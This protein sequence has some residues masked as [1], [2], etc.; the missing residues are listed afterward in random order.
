M[1]AITYKGIYLAYKFAVSTILVALF[2]FL[3]SAQNAYAHF[4]HFEPR[5]IHISEK[6]GGLQILL[7]MPLPLLL[8]DTSWRGFDSLQNVPF[9][10]QKQTEEGTQYIVDTSAIEQQFPVFSQLVTDNYTLKHANRPQ[11]SMKVTHVHIFNSDRRK[12]FSSLQ[13]AEQSFT[14]GDI[15]VDAD[16]SNLFESSIDVRLFV[17]FAVFDDSY[18]IDSDLGIHLNAIEKLA[19]IVQVHSQEGT[20]STYSSIGPLHLQFEPERGPL[21]AFTHQLGNGV[22]HILIGLD[23]VLFVLLIA[24][25]STSWLQTLKRATA[26]TIGHSIT[27]AMGLYGLIPVGTWFIPAIEILIALTILYAAIA[28]ILKR[29]EIFGYLTISFVGLIHGFG[30]SFV[31]NELVGEA[32]GLNILDLFAFNL[33]IEFGQLV[34]YGI[35]AVLLLFNRWV[36][37]LQRLQL[38]KWLSLTAILLSIFWVSERSFLLLA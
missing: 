3:M 13:L 35:F 2:L 21:E 5:I 10:Y 29:Q 22:F 1:R 23:H 6:Q 7:R 19:N 28:V 20:S 14:R 31:L 24:L 17:P 11:D 33:G 18:T 4:T 15:V 36:D 12:P 25:A 27:L 16:A 37:P 30:F 26:F 32:G 38:P 9:T 8:L 34:I